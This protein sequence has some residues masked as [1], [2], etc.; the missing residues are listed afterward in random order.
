MDEPLTRVSAVVCDDRITVRE[1]YTCAC[2]ATGLE[3]V[4]EA[5]NF[6]ELTE[7]VRIIRPDVAVATLPAR[8]VNEVQRLRDLAP[9]CCVVILSP[10]VGLQEAVLAA[11]A[12]AA[13][14]EG[15]ARALVRVLQGVVK[16]IRKR[17]SPGAAGLLRPR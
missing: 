8:G 7:L 6:T 14:V 16:G 10:F 12:A 4:A 13:L 17:K 1:A 9:T 2:A 3:V 15:D 5:V 11:G